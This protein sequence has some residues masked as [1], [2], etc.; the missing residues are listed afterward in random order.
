MLDWVS[1][2][3][4]S[5]QHDFTDWYPSQTPFKIS[6]GNDNWTSVSSYTGNVE[7]IWFIFNS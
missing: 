2:L 1:S 4:T 7:D 5:V 6:I 3:K